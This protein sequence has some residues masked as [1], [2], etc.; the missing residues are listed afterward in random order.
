MYHFPNHIDVVFPY[1]HTDTVLEHD[2][3]Y[4]NYCIIQIPK[5]IRSTNI[6][7]ISVHVL[8]TELQVSMGSTAGGSSRPPDFGGKVF[9][10]IHPSQPPIL[11]A[12]VVKFL[13]L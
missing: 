6:R 10:I 1:T 12:L 4:A 5:V 2:N 9:N 8:R 11:A 7:L 13:T 3:Q